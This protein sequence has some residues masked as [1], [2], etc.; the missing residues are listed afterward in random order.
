MPFHERRECD[1]GQIVASL[2]ES[3]EQLT[4]GQS[5]D[6]ARSEDTM[7]ES[8]NGSVLSIRHKIVL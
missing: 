2:R 3:C 8:H 7:D 1:L 5:R 4:V 6:R